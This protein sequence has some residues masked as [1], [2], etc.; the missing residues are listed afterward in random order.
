MHS[1]I[2]APA[3]VDR[4]GGNPVELRAGDVVTWS[5]SALEPLADRFVRD[6]DRVCGLRLGAG[7]AAAGVI[8]VALVERV[9]EF[10]SLPRTHGVSP[11]GGDPIDERYH[12][13]VRDGRIRIAGTRSE[14]VHRALTSLIQLIGVLPDGAGGVQLTPIEIHDAPRYAWR[15][16]SLDVVR[17][18]MPAA[19]V[20]Q[21]VDQ[22]ARFK[23][24]VLHLH[25]TDSQGWRLEIGQRPRLTEVGGATAMGDRPGGFY[26]RQDY[27]DLVEYAAD[28]FVTVVPEIDLPG[29]SA[30]ALAAYPELRP[31]GAT[32][33]ALD[34]AVPGTMDFVREVLT[35]VAAL[36]PGAYLH[37]GGD[38]VFGMDDD[39]YRRFV[40]ETHAIVHELGKRPVSW[41][42]SARAGAASVSQ[43]W[44]DGP[45]DVSMLENAAAHGIDIP[46]EMLPSIEHSL[47]Q[48]RGDAALA[49]AAGATIL[50]SPST[51]IYLD[52]PYT[53]AGAP[54]QEERR[55]RLGLPLYQGTTVES[56]ADWEPLDVHNDIDA[57]EQI[58][59]I[60][61]ALWCETVDRFE[62]AQFLM[63]PRLAGAAERAWSPAGPF[64]WTDYAARL[65]AQAP[66]WRRDGWDFFRSG[67][68]DWA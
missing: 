54:E 12:L 63:Q 15:G 2:P 68:V 10:D 46:A 13:S 39:A 44:M 24:N 34:P 31:A 58:A 36:T 50:L 1:I 52:N 65:A 41:Q 23:M 11:T 48:A 6:V 55:A 26:T 8:D 62:D 59:G 35:E 60:E 17:R 14:G 42:E 67:A 21:V 49:L 47:R 43:Y 28:R 57:E 38:E 56:A 20:R 18:F 29:H 5:D 45:A 51:L 16:L 19:E 66:L 40:T 7:P 22:L 4:P 53:E 3:R 61:A 30:A 37:V 25:L 33:E 32:S 64:D 9:P 27:R